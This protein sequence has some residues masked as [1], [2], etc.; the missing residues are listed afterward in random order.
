MDHEY[1]DPPSLITLTFHYIARG[2]GSD[3]PPIERCEL[4]L[5]TI[6]PDGAAECGA[7]ACPTCGVSGATLSIEE[8]MWAETR[9]AT[10]RHCG[11]SWPIAFD[12]PS[13]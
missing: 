3:R 11:H 7:L 13:R 4:N 9:H 10:C 8:D 2:N 6:D 1:D 5:C 12:A